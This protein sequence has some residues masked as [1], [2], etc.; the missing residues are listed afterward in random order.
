M[1]FSDLGLSPQLLRALD[2]NKYRELSPVQKKAIPLIAAG[3]DMI[4]CAQTG[5]GKTAAFSLPLIEK[6]AKAK[7]SWRRATVLVLSPTR[8]LALQISENINT[9]SK[10]L[11]IRCTA[12]Y[13]GVAKSPQV[14][15][16]AKV[17]ILL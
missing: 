15:V 16:L 14:K 4:A 2:E 6:I 9:Y 1:K 8:E 12:I 5:T 3:H 7:E 13:G 10:Y 17:C 11:P